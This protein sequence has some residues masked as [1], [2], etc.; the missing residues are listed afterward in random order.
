MGGANHGPRVTSHQSPDLP[1]VV[2]EFLEVL[3][4]VQ[5]SGRVEVDVEQGLAEVVVLGGEHLQLGFG[6][7]IMRFRPRDISGFIEKHY[8]Q[9]VS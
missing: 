7:G 6:R 4:G 1:G 2:L 8:D 9:I 5:W 3:E